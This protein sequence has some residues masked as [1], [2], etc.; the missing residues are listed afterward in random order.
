MDS[1]IRVVIEREIISLQDLLD[2]TDNCIGDTDTPKSTLVMYERCL[3][4]GLRRFEDSWSQNVTILS[5]DSEYDSLCRSYRAITRCVRKAIATAQ[6]TM[7]EI[8]TGDINQQPALPPPSAP[9]NPLPPPK[10]PAIK[11]PEFSGGEEQWLAFWDIFNSLVHDRMD[12]SNVIKFSTLRAS[13]KD[14][15]FKAI[16]GLPVTNANYSVAI[17]TL[18][19]KYDNKDKL[20]RRLMS[21]LT[22]LV[23]PSHTIE[24]LNTFKL[25]YE[26]IILQMNTLNLDVE[27]MNPIFSS[28]ICEKLSPETRKAIANKHNSMSLDLKQ[29]SS[30]LKYVCELMEFCYEGENSNKRKRDQGN[31]SKVIPSNVQSVQRAQQSNSKPSNSSSYHNCVFCSSNHASRDCKTF[32]TI[33]SRRDRVKYLRLCFACLKGGHLFS[34]CRNKPK[35]NI[36]DGPHYPMICKKTE[37]PVNPAPP[38]L[39]VNSTNVS[40]S[41]VNSGKSHNDSKGAV[42]KGDSPVVMTASLGIDHSQTNKISVSTALPTA[43]V[44][45]SGN[46]HRSFGRALFDSGAQ[47]TFIATELVHKLSLPSIA[48]V[49]LKV[50]PFGSDAM[51]VNCNIVRVVVRLGKIRT[52]INAIAFDRVNSRIY[53]PGLSKSA[54]FLT[55][56]GIKLADNDLNSD[57]VNGIELVI[58]ADY[59]GKFIHNSQICSGIQILNSSGGALIF[60]PLPSWSYDDVES[61]EITTSNV[62]CS[63]IEV[64]EIPINSCCE[65]RKLWDLESVGIRQSEISPEERESVKCFKDKVKRVDNKYEVSLPFKDESRPPVNYRIAIG[66]LNSSLHRFESDPSLY[67]HY[68]KIIKD[69]VQSGFIEFIPSGSPIIGH[70]LPHHAVLK[71]SETTPIRI[72]FNASSKAKG[73]LSLNDCLLTG[74]SLTTKLFDA[75]LSFRTNPVAVISD[76][77]KAFLRIGISPDCRDYC[78]FLWITDPSDLKSTVTYRFCVVCFGATCS[79][80]LLQQT[81]LHHLSLHDNPLAS[82]LMKNFYVDNFSKTYKDVSVLMDEYPVINEILEDANMPLQEWV[83]N[84]S[85]FNRTIDVIKERVNVLGLEW[86]LTQDEMSLKEVN[87]EYKGPLTKRKVLSVIARMFDPLGLLS[88]IQVRGKYFLKC[89]WSNYGWD[90]PLPESLCSRFDEIC[91]CIRNVESLK[92]P[93]FVVHPE[94]SHL[95]VFC[96]ASNKAYGAAAYVIDFRRSVGNLLVS[97]CKVAPNPKQTIPRLELTALS[98]GAKLAGRLMQNDDLRLSSCTLWSDSMVSIC[99]VK[100]NNSK[101]PY[102]RNRVTEINEFKFPLRYTPSKDNPADILSRGSTSKD[103]AQ[104]SLW[105]NGPK[106]L[107]TGDYPQSLATETVHVNEILSEPKFVNPPTP[108]IDIPRYSNLS[109]LKRIMRSILLFL[110]KCSKGSKFV[111]NEMKALVL[112]EQKQHFSTTRMYLCDKNSHGVSMDIKNFCNQLNLFVD[113][114]NLIRSQGRMKNASMS[115]DTQCPMLL[116]SRSYLTVLIVEHL[117]RHHHHCGVNSVLVLLRETFWV[118]KARQVIKSILSK[119]V[120]CQK[121][122]KKRLCLPPPPPLP[123]ERVRY[124]RSFQSVGVDYTGAINVFDHET[125]LEEKVFI[126]LFTC[127]TS[128]AVHFELTHSMTASDFL[129]AFRRFVAYHSL[130]SLIISDNGRNFVGFNNFLKE[131][132]D[133]PEVKSY[134]EGNCVNWKFITPRAPWSGGFYERLIG[135]LKGCLSKALYHKRVSFEELRTLLVEFQAVINSRPLTYLSSDRDCEALTPSMLLYGRNICISP[136]LNNSATDDPDFMSSSDLREQYFRLSSVLRKFENSWKR[137]YLVSLRERHFN[138]SD[139]LSANVKVG[140]IVMVDLDDHL[141]K[142]YRS[143]LSLGKV[144]QLFPSSDGVIRSVEVSE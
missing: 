61:N 7:S 120:L 132:M 108:L 71:D 79:P 48:T 138:S 77:S 16:E 20:K 52:V 94:G 28:I 13:L 101:I 81:L 59:Y 56:K 140:D 89:L 4:E 99:W 105:W 32:K 117:H 109:K 83:S 127:T 15:A 96:D 2:E 18:K 67:A 106:W 33:D 5:Q 24:D 40:K 63:R 30:G 103:L 11:I 85:E 143:L 95:H 29:I 42:S 14:N 57:E 98:L 21:K 45:V 50:K 133:E 113:E 90:D 111:V 73:E 74:P 26:K 82:S 123:T 128:R 80:F 137:D 102:V 68:D 41:N 17:Q 122:T 23:P 78:R 1:K 125:G 66:Q 9:I 8:D 130:P 88:P 72:V 124:D 35:C 38:K 62:C 37:N 97:K 104:N 47:R 139:Y 53:S 25:E 60:G 27:A 119:C 64:E 12:I 22:H 49:A 131:I 84:D 107:L 86:Y 55:S 19:E 116:P 136:P 92:F 58:G 3:I 31:Y 44:I 144:T 93:R 114:E 46:G 76:I 141:G 10:L 118:P 100:N 65:V 70:Y 69:Y 54:A 34:E 115:Y 134:L 110:N 91:K 75:L 135:V 51:E 112:L 87:C 36:C 43:N 142:G 126:C 129:L 6:K 39:S 121:L